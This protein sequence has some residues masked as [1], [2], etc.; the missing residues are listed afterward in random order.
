MQRG[1]GLSTPL[2]TS[3]M[4]QMKSAE[5][6]VDYLKHFRA[7][8]IVNDAEFIRKRLVPYEGPWKVLGQV[9]RLIFIVGYSFLLSLAFTRLIQEGSSVPFIPFD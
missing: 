6:L 9:P 8:N 2:T 5:D 1:T 7:D 3:S 4:L